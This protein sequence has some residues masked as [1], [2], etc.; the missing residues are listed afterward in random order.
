ML[1]N[2]AL[3]RRVPPM[4][5]AAEMPQRLIPY[6]GRLVPIEVPGRS[7]PVMAMD[8]TDEEEMPSTEES[9]GSNVRDFVA[10]EEE[11][12]D[13]ARRRGEDVDQEAVVVAPRDACA[14]LG[15]SRADVAW[16]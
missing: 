15:A 7:G 8:L 4:D 9:S 12:A 13:G 10:E 5:R 16:Y 6:Q 11:Q 3:S 1:L 14:E 2:A